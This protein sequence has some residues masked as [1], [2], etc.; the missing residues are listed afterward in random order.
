M[1]TQDWAERLVA[2]GFPYSQVRQ[3]D[4]IGARWAIKL[5]RAERRRTLRLIHGLRL[6]AGIRRSISEGY[7]MGYRRALDDLA[8]KV[9][10]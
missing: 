1:P 8:E 2:R 7:N 4:L 10:G 6:P 5:L 3:Q 9:R